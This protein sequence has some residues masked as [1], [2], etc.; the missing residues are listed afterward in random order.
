MTSC[1]CR[2]FFLIILY[3][4]NRCRSGKDCNT[5]YSLFQRKAAVK[6]FH[7]R[8]GPADHFFRN[9]QSE[10]IDGFQKYPGSLHQSLSH[11][12][13]GGLSE[14]SAFRVLQM[15]A[16][17]N[18]GDLHIRDGRTGEHSSV[19]LFFQMCQYQS[20]PVS[21]KNILTAVCGKQ[22][23]ASRLCRFQKQM[24]LRIVP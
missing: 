15:G 8:H 9:L 7:I 22:K 11:R 21:G 13:V 4:H 20:L 6:L 12:P 17:G 1:V 14:I 10:F 2:H 16:S 24:N 5:A 18:K 19:F 3:R 23:T